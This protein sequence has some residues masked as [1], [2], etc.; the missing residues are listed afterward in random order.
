MRFRSLLGLCGLALVVCL[1]AGATVP[2]GYMTVSSSQ[3]TDVAGNPVTN[4]TITWAPVNNAGVATAARIGAGGQGVAV[5]VFARVIAGAFALNVADTYETN[6]QNICY[7]VTVTDN[8]SGETL[9]NY[10]C[11]QPASSGAS[12]WCTPGSG[13]AGGTCNF[14]QFI[15]PTPAGTM[16]GVGPTGPTGASGT[17]CASGSSPSTCNFNGTLDVSVAVNA[18]LTGS[19][20]VP[21]ATVGDPTTVP[22]LIGQ[23]EPL[24]PAALRGLRTKMALMALYNGGGGFGGG[25]PAQAIIMQGG[26]STGGFH[27]G[28]MIC[29]LEAQFGYAGYILAAPS[30]N[31]TEYGFN[32]P[33]A[34]GGWGTP[35]LTGGAAAVSGDFNHFPGGTGWSIPSGGSAA[36][37]FGFTSTRQM[38]YYTADASGATVT[39]STST[40]GTTYTPLSGCN[41]VSVTAHVGGVCDQTLSAGNYYLKI[42]VGGTGTVYLWTVGQINTGINGV[43]PSLLAVGGQSLPDEASIPSAVW[44]PWLNDI[45]PDAVTFEMKD[46]GTM[47]TG[48]PTCAQATTAAPTVGQSRSYWWGLWIAPFLTANPLADVVIFGSYDISD[49]CIPVYNQ[50]EQA[51]AY[52]VSPEQTYVDNYWQL[53]NAQMQTLGWIDTSVHETALGQVAHGDLDIQYLGITTWPTAVIAQNVNSP[54]YVES[55]LFIVGGQSQTIQGWDPNDTLASSRDF[56]IKPGRGFRFTSAAGHSF[57]YLGSMQEGFPQATNWLAP[58]QLSDTSGTTNSGRWLAAPS[59]QSGVYSNLG[60]GTPADWWAGVVHAS[61]YN[62]SGGS[63]YS[64]TKTAGSCVLTISGGII[65]NVTGC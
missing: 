3:L 48:Y 22:N 17:N 27:A 19:N 53:T 64:G 45:R 2:A 39:I 40:N 55:P 38:V 32:C 25:N 43:V 16:I 62:S 46:N 50:V 52:S 10:P 51:W 30:G 13:G 57:G 56:T 18:P 21:S 6:P 36:S 26:D 7:S 33:T 31:V 14:D 28:E 24:H 15:P 5:P 11:V 1:S 54:N 63:G 23:L 29:T 37:Q 47:V 49:K 8:T 65:T 58:F 59:G 44:Q 4:A 42:S 35:S 9:L 20:P 60:A 41:G 61:S 12:Y 34:F